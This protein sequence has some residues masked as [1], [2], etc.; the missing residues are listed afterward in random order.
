MSSL[1][2]ELKIKQMAQHWDMFVD[3]PSWCAHHY[4]KSMQV[5]KTHFRKCE[6]QLSGKHRNRC[7]SLMGE[8]CGCWSGFRWE[9]GK[10]T[11][12][13]EKS[14]EYCCQ[15]REKPGCLSPRHWNHEPWGWHFCSVEIICVSW[16][17]ADR[18]LRNFTELK[19]QSVIY[20]L[21]GRL[22]CDGCTS[23]K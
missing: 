4:V 7:N 18:L 17:K 10:D 21:H 6:P 1:F 8:H 14:L 22:K 23:Y 20:S 15:V 12:I 19:L 13:R 2:P 11:S 9:L 5:V 16:M 3:C